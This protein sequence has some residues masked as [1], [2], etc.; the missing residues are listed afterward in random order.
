LGLQVAQWLARKGAKNLVL[1]GRSKPNNTAQNLIGEL[2]QDGV[3]VLVTSCDLTDETEVIQL[4]QQI[5]QQ[6]PSLKGVIHA[7]GVLDDG[8][9][10]SLTWERFETVMAPKVTGTWNLHQSSLDL[11]LD[12][13]ICF[14][15]AA[16]LLGASGQGNYAAA[17]SFMDAIAH[18][19]QAQGLPALSINWG[20]WESGGMATTLKEASKQRLLQMGLGMIPPQEGLKI[21]EQLLNVASPQIGVMQMDWETLFT[22]FPPGFEVPFLENL[23]ES[24]SA[25]SPQTTESEFLVTLKAA[26]SNEQRNLLIDFIRQQLAKVLGLNSS[27]N[28]NPD[29]RL[30][31]LG[32]D[33]LMA[34]ELNN[35]FEIHLGCALNQSVIFNYPTVETLADYLAQELLG[36]TPIV[37]SIQPTIIPGTA[38]PVSFE[39]EDLD[40]LLAELETVSDQE[41]RAR[42]TR[43]E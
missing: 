11:E 43:K 17:N 21:L 8:T 1:T 5:Q 2:Q 33:S 10:S 25:T 14:S 27:D 40:D 39:N 23:R 41:I 36:I 22:Q 6:F 37:T 13:F 4:F 32:L 7:A 35:R 20:T 26:P 19:R 38:A 18:Y 28:I 29:A 16:A 15:S 31:D 12:F 30:F 24:S 42:L 3:D 9:L 34:I